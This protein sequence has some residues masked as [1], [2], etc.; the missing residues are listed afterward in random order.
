VNIV[1]AFQCE[2]CEKVYKNKDSCRKHEKQCFANPIMK[3]CRSCKYAI[4]DSETVY[5]R[6]HGDQNYG[7]A[8][9]DIEFTYCE[10][11]EKSLNYP[12]KPISFKSNCPYYSQGERLF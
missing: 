11:T 2:F 3:A 7:D 12:G 6:P 10:I 8:D 5:E 4:K 1:Q 9:Y